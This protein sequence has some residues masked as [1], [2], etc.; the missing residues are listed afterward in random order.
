MFASF[1]EQ[2]KE[3]KKVFYQKIK[4]KEEKEKQK[5]LDKINEGF[6]G[7][8]LEPFADIAYTWRRAS[9]KNKEIQAKIQ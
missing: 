2:D 8:F 7:W 6:F 1:V 5:H 9:E 3:I 4:E